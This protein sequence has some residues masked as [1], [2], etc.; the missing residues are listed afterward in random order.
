[1]TEHIEICWTGNTKNR[2]IRKTA[3]ALSQMI[4]SARRSILIVGYAIN[5]KMGDILQSLEERSND[6]VKL[7]F[8]INRLEEKKDFLEWAK[9]LSNP[10]ELYD[11]QENPN[12]PMSSLHVKCV[13]VDEKMAMF[14]SANLT[15]H[16][17]KANRE[18]GIIIKDDSVVKTIVNLLDELKEELVRF[19]LSDAD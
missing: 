1:M 14:G 19:D 15:F 16:G 6:G 13:I 11:K 3:P 18:L 7:V 8:M 5:A 17:M 4:I 9:R 2:H 10:P 12:D